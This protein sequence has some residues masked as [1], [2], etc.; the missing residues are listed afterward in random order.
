MFGSKGTW[1]PGPALR[2]EL[3]PMECD[4][5]LGKNRILSKKIIDVKVNLLNVSSSTSQIINTLLMMNKLI[6]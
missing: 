6:Y 4:T 1:L 5:T 3:K 2:W